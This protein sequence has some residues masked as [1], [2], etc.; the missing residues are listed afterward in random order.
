MYRQGD[1][2]IIK[3]NEI[4]QGVR[5]I[6]DSVILRGEATGHAHKL[7]GGL[8]M[9]NGQIYLKVDN[10]ADIVHEEHATI[11]LKSGNY[12]VIRQREYVS[13]EEERYV[14]D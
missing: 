10:E 11:H 13:K 5:I 9:S 2:L 14:A 8:V 1:L 4:P 3:I 7:E 6:E 12:A